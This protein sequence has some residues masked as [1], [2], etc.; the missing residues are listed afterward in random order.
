M[1][2]KINTVVQKV[3]G[4]D[5]KFTQVT[6]NLFEPNKD[7]IPTLN[8]GISKDNRLIRVIRIEFHDNS[9]NDYDEIEEVVEQ[10]LKIAKEVENNLPK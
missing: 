5:S 4:Q 1:R 9:H 2:E 10:S 8:V 3:Y 6:T 7:G